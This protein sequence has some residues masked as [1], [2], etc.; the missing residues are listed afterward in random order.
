MEMHH[1]YSSLTFSIAEPAVVRK[2]I[3]SAG[4]TLA[5]WP[6]ARPD[7]SKQMIT[8]PILFIFGINF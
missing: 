1:T 3:W 2:V 7:R 8:K 4:S 5:S 6:T